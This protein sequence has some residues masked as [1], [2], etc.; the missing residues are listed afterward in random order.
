MNKFIIAVTILVSLG[1]L[2]AQNIEQIDA[3]LIEG[4]VSKALIEIETHL[5]D[6]GAQQKLLLSSRKAE[7][8]VRAGRFDDAEATLKEINLS[9]LNDDEKATVMSGYGF[10]YLNQ[11]RNDLALDNLE[12]AMKLWEGTSKLNTLG[13]AQTQSHLG[14][15]FLA[16]GK[17]EQ[18]EEHLSV[19]LITRQSLLAANH[20]LVAASLND[21]GLLYSF[22]DSDKALA[23]YEKASA[24]Y[25][26]LHGANH[27]KIA[28]A[29]TNMGYLYLKMELFGDAI[30]NFESA[31]AIW[32][33]VFPGAHP[34]KAFVLFSLGR[35]SQA[36]NDPASA[37]SYYLKAEEQYKLSYGAKHPDI[38]RVYNALG[39]LDQAENK[40]NSALGYFQQAI[41]ANHPS[42]QSQ[43][44]E[45]N[46]AVGDFYDGNT[47]LYS[48]LYK[49]QTFEL[50]YFRKSLRFKELL[51]AIRTLQSCDTLI[52]RLRQQ[53]R[54]ES[55]KIALGA[56]AAEVY[57]DGVRIALEASEAALE[58]MPLKLQGFYFAE[59]SKAAVLLGAISEANAKSFAGIPPSL[60]EEEKRIKAAIS[61]VTQK[62]ALMPAKEEEKYL[63][64]TYYE[65]N[66][67][68]DLFS[69]RLE[70]EF[71]SYYNLKYNTAAPSVNLL[72]EKLSEATLLISYFIEEKN[73]RIYIFKVSKRGLTVESRALP[74]DFDRY[75]TG[76]RNGIFYSERQTYTTSAEVLSGVLLPRIPSGINDLVIVP[77]GKLA[78]VP[79]ETLFTD[80]PSAEQ[81]F[82][83]LPYLVN[84]YAV[85]YEFSAGL[86]LQKLPRA[87]ERRPSILLCAPVAFNHS[88]GL[89]NLPGTE[90]EVKEIS[91]LFASRKLSANLL[92][93][94]NAD[95]GTI[96]KE[97]LKEYSLLHFATHGV[98]D[99]KNPALSRI[100]LAGVADEDGTLYT[101]EI[102]N[103]ALDANLVTLSACQTGLG[104]ITKGEGVVGLSRAL[105]FAGARNCLVSFWSVSDQSTALLMQNYYTKL[106]DAQSHNYSA[107]LRLAK[108]DLIATGRYAS[109][110]YWAPFIHI[111]F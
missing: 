61:L 21:L 31:L 70:S 93:N 73:N 100:Y 110:Y 80:N 55:D 64:Q 25:E 32:S 69:R 28:V 20:E 37:R 54:N 75:L 108:K 76:L 105:L 60:L 45:A 77:A 35:T 49:A 36:M 8:L 99:Q 29:N 81:G 47:L 9:T 2:Q 5:K 23:H 12:N 39:N 27:P 51:A 67:K 106:L 13:A 107:T 63:R 66:R 10:L 68:Y 7:A 53:T 88:T 101:G 46:P 24:I 79:F 38:A 33:S 30:N 48:L 90:A 14:N 65:L 16:T 102:Y 78:T 97:N 1:Q 92:L 71:P 83:D 43:S 11:G 56:I 40:F 3:L 42:F 18:A 109:P 87:N 104:K 15:L 86:I 84:K 72:R 94:N 41:E 52:D 6:A 4:D 111:G 85:R 57:G 17:Y 103:L 91:A 44:P 22:I 59:K 98:V 95:E 58:K 82:A 89:A 26:T 50:K 19:A 74:A 34:S 62:L 96:K